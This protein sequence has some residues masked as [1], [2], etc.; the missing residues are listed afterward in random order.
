MLKKL[1]EQ[2]KKLSAPVKASLWFLICGFLQKGISMLTTPVFTRIM[3]EEQYGKFSVYHTWLSVVQIIVTLNLAAGVYVRGLVKNEDDQDRFSSAM[4]GLSTTC[5]LV[6][7]VIYALFRNAFNNLLGI[8]TVMVA[9]MLV[10]AWAQIAYQFW[11]NREKVAY[12]YKKLVILTLTY[13]T[14]KPALG[15]VCVLWADEMQQAEARILAT[16]VINLLLFTGLYITIFKKGRQFFNKKYWL[17]AL[18]FN[19]PLLPH[20]LSQ[21]VFNQ[22]DRLM[23]NS[24]CGPSEAAYYTVAY[25]I[26]MVLQILNTSVS[27]TMNPWIYRSLKDKQY[28]NIGKVSYSILGVIA[29]LNLAVV[30]GAPEVLRIMAPESYQAALWVIP[31]VTVGVYFSFLCDVFVAFEFYFEKTHYVTIATIANAV[32]NVVLNAFFIPRFGFVAAGYT[33]LCCFILYAFTHYLIM[34]RI[35]KTY[36]DNAKIYNSKIIV[37]LGV[38]LMAGAAATMLLYKTVL[39]RY[40]LLLVLGALAVWKRKKIAGLLKTMKMK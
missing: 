19:I 8:S 2:Y 21:I 12:R 32:L 27:A 6:W 14:L 28:K 9:A 1:L 35:V 37:G 7:T 16:V 33:T 34:K 4:L 20:Y 10:E 26:A 23:I 40:G 36:L 3:T 24:I 18:K 25:T 38:C 39:I 29:L 17:Y 13:V 5:I 31:P 11:T 15:A 22:S 30:L